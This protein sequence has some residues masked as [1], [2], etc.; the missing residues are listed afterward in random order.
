[1]S[2]KVSEPTKE[3]FDEWKGSPVGVWFFSLFA[4]AVEKTVDNWSKTTFENPP[5][6]M[7]PLFLAQS[8]AKAQ[9]FR[10]VGSSDWYDL[11]G[12]E[13]PSDDEGADDGEA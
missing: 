13:R 5:E 11:T 6:A 2:Q 1:M 8:Q 10:E 9:A 12:N 7:S 4:D 3:A